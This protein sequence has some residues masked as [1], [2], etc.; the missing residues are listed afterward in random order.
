MEEA[1]E[2][3][4]YLPASLKTPSEQEYISFLWEVFDANHTNGQ[5]Q[6]AFLA[7]H[8]LMMSFI[9]F[10][11]WQI[12][13]TR[14]KDFRNSLI[15]FPREEKALLTATSPFTFSTVNERA[16]LRFLKLIACDDSEIGAYRKLVDDRNDIAHSNGNLFLKDKISLESKISEILRVVDEIQAH[17]KPVI[18][19]CYREFLLQ[20]RDVDQREH[21]DAGDQ[22]REV[23][24]R[25]S[26]LSQKDIESCIQFDISGL[27][28]FGEIETL[29]RA[30]CEAYAI[31]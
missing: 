14:P 1:F 9:Y 16:V 6:F 24:I 8:M 21:L 2:L 5:Y 7:Y 26:Y 22:I 31:E 25:G 28:Q 17:S 13:Q 29:H 4:S 27:K 12:R 10:N 30:L 3:S 18:E 23:L 11:I 15:G 19:D 20:S